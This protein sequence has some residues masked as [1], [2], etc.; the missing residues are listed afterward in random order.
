MIITKDPIPCLYTPDPNLNLKFLQSDVKDVMNKEN[1]GDLTHPHDPTDLYN[2]IQNLLKDAKD[3]DVSPKIQADIQAFINS[4]Q[5]EFFIPDVDPQNPN[6]L[7]Y[8]IPNQ[9]DQPV[10]FADFYQKATSGDGRDMR[11]YNSAH[12]TY[13]HGPASR[14]LQYYTGATLSDGGL[15]QSA[16]LLDL[17]V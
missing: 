15:A 6:P 7:V 14:F 2:A 12:D 16:L 10:S 9:P 13:I 3:L 8:N 5:A 1:N 4:I 11:Y 17:M